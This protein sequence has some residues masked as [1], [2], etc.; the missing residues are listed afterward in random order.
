MLRGPEKPPNQGTTPWQ[1]MGITDGVST[2]S[3][4]RREQ[5]LGEPRRRI[6]EF[7]EHLACVLS[8]APGRLPLTLL[9]LENEHLQ[10]KDV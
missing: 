9:I 8:A 7:R 3:G 5:L 6:V 10:C 1:K 2:W 4:A